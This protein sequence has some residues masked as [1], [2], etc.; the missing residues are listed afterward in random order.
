ME[1]TQQATDFQKYLAI[2]NDSGVRHSQSKEEFGA[3]AIAT[4]NGLF[5]FND[6][7]KLKVYITVA[8]EQKNV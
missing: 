7:G 6:A 5:L 3:L 8:P 4:E 1:K 2:M